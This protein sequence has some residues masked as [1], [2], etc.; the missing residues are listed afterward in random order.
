[1]NPSLR[2]R[3]L[4][5]L[6]LPAALG[7]PTPSS[8]APV[9]ASQ[10]RE[11]TVCMAV[12]DAGSTGTRL[13]LY[14]S[15]GEAGWTQQG[16]L[17]AGAVADPIR[18][19]RGKSWADAEAVAVEIAGLLPQLQ[20]DYDWSRRC[21]LAS[22]T[23]LATAGM[24][25]AEQAQPERAA[26]MYAAVEAAIGRELEAAGVEAPVEART[27]TGFEE[28]LYAWLALPGGPSPNLGLVEMG[29]ASAQVVFPCPGCE[30]A[31]PVRVGDAS[32]SIVSHSFLGLGENEAPAAICAGVDGPPP[33][34]AYGVGLDDP[35]WSPAA[36]VAT[37][38]F[39]GGS[40]DGGIVDP[41]NYGAQGQGSTV[42]L[43]VERFTGE[44]RLT[45]GLAYAKAGDVD[46]CC[47]NRGEGCYDPPQSCFS[48]VYR[49][50]FL[51]AIG[52]PIDAR[53]ADS[54]WTLGFVM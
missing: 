25:L 7:C 54:S 19:I 35:S 23:L 16:R 4:L 41:Y 48:A 30:E 40:D 8:R 51:E 18:E 2:P 50:A 17:R 52:V 42:S 9:V 44:W 43:P 26:T 46:D 12:Y 14:V 3:S 34:C 47:R 38:N 31:L 49:S 53:A 39:S 36:G 28:G 13:H 32:M 21:R 45:G 11:D 27:L 15:E 29:G 33:A 20:T 24:R 6:L 1:M 5:C 37:M 22:V 10:E